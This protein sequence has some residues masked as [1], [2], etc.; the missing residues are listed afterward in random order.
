MLIYGRHPTLTALREGQVRQLFL[1]H[2][3]ERA[4]R[5]EFEREA[6]RFGVPVELVPRIQLDQAVRT[7]QHQGVAAEIAELAYAD[8]DAPFDLALERRE[9]LLLVCLDG[10]T[11]PRNYGAIVRSAEALGAH[12]VV[13]EARRSAPLSPVVAKTAAGATA[14]LPL[15]QVTNLP[16]YLAELKDRAVWVYGADAAREGGA[17]RGPREVDWSRDVALVIGAEGEGLRRVV[18][19]A[20]DELVEVPL[21]GR[22]PS[23]NASVAA[24]LLIHEAL[25]AREAEAEAEAGAEA[26]AE[27]RAEAEAEARAEAEAEARA[28]RRPRRG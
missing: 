3:I 27:A 11:D 12:G 4:A 19:A 9:R 24:A 26:E 18:R 5:A 16:R 8:P 25:M 13:T 1:A 28:D 21:R 2:G 20:C 22:T 7:T 6:A 17:T 14:H 10:V 15:L 23:L